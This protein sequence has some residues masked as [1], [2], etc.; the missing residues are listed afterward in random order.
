MALI[1]GL[2]IGTRSVTGAVFAGSPKK[3]RLV[4][5]F[6]EEIQPPDTG[7]VLLARSDSSAPAEFVPPPSLEEI[8]QKVLADKGLLGCEVVVAVDSKDCTIREIPVQFTKDEQIEKVI[9]YSAEEFLPTIQVEEVILDY[10]KVGESQG[11]STVILFALRNE[12]MEQR[13]ALLKRLDID[14]VAVDLDT[15]ALFNAFALSP[16]HAANKAT[17]LVDMGANSTKIVLVEEGRLTK[18]RSFRSAIRALGPERLLAQP[19]GAGALAT[20][21][22]GAGGDSEPL[23]GEYS[24]ES[25]FKEIEDALRKLEPPTAETS[26]DD[27]DASAPIA[28]LSDE[29]YARVQ[30]ELSGRSK[31]AEDLPT[32]EQLFERVE[33]P[34]S[35]GKASG[36]DFRAYLDR[37]GIEVQRTLASSRAQVELICLTGGGSAR[38]EAARYFSEEFDVET[39]RLDFGDAIETDL[40]AERLAEVSRFGAVAVGLAIK[41]LGGDRTGLDFRKGRFRFEHR[42]AKLKFP[43]LVASILCFVFFLQL[44]FWS[45]HEYQ[46]L[47]ELAQDYD[48]ESNKVYQTFFETPLV[49]GREPLA[50]AREQIK[51]WGGRGLEGV[52]K[53]LPYQATLKNLAEVMDNAKN[54]LRGIFRI[55]NINL[56]LKVKSRTAVTG[57]KKTTGLMSEADSSMEVLSRSDDANHTLAKKFTSDQISKFF[58]AK[59]T[60]KKV[61]GDF[62]YQVTVTLTPKPSALR[63][64]E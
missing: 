18:V 1:L 64:L 19:V 6:R 7:P 24:I 61:T 17:L 13:L 30:D 28:I 51:K 12:I 42:F 45:Y 23:F 3:F 41:E 56:E 10:L 62:E 49:E 4:D 46:S 31:P 55:R 27:F 36:S 33:A 48:Q 39:T 43:L 37:L 52:G 35:N 54:D 57:G 5:F 26:L 44:A 38:E 22:G 29:D 47:N 16:L 14:P 11:K 53:V 25:R 9:P 20:G 63:S 8:L 15:A 40:D 34:P 2:D 32:P 58:D 21:S 59:C 60:L 50:A